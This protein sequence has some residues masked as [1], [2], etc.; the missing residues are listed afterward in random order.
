MTYSF[1]YVICYINSFVIV[2][3]LEVSNSEP[4]LYV[5][6]SHVENG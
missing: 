6:V 1:P 5:I 4:V 3:K 2:K